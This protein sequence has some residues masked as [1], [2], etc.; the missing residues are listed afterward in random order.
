MVEG[1]G[2]YGDI[3]QFLP[4]A[5]I[6]ELVSDEF[7]TSSLT[8]LSQT[9]DFVIMGAIFYFLNR[10]QRQCGAQSAVCSAQMVEF[11]VSVL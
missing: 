3:V 1:F 8:L 6:K 4:P 5:Q 2:I 10:F 7:V 11:C 9:E